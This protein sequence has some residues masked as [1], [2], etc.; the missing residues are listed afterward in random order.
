MVYTIASGDN[1]WT[2]GNL[3][4][5]CTFTDTFANS[6]TRSNNYTTANTLAGDAHLPVISTA[7]LSPSRYFYIL[8]QILFITIQFN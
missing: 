2:S 8:I 5:T 1:D 4:Y 3:P 7:T 6:I